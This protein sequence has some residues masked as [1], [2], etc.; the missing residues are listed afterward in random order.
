[1]AVPILLLVVAALAPSILHADGAELFASHCATCHGDLGAGDGPASADLEVE[2]R[3]LRYIAVRNGGSFPR[4]LVQRIIDGRKFRQ[5]HLRG[6]MPVWG[7]I[8]SR[9]AG[10]RVAKRRIHELAS[11]L[12]SI[13]LD[14]EEQPMAPRQPPASAEQIRRGEYLVALLGCGRCHTEGELLG[15]R[16]GPWLAGSTR[17]IAYTRYVEGRA[18]GIVFPANLTPDPETGL[19]S[20][21]RA[22]IASLITRGM[23]SAGHRASPVMPWAAYSILKPEDAEAIA[24]YLKQLPAVRR[25]IP[26]AIP[27]GVEANARYVRFSI[28]TFD[29]GTAPAVVPV[30]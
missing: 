20:R 17:G 18:P 8:F 22:D 9:E 27:E 14:E 2:L 19:G 1:M 10:P 11:Y 21:S 28:Y 4:R 16:E 6:G 29:P 3:D 25:E 12:E 24:A 23:D 30:P 26:E 7:E 13:Q 15:R 5:S